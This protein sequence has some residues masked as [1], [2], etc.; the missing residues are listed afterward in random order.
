[1]R[2]EKELTTEGVAKKKTSRAAYYREY[3]KKNKEKINAQKRAAY[4]KRKE[5]NSSAAEEINVD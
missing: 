5:L 1:M 4:A 3:R 2:T